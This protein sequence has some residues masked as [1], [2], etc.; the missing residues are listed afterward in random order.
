METF[1]STTETFP[2]TMETFPS[3]TETFQS[4]IATIQSGNATAQP[5][6]QHTLGVALDYPASDFAKR[7]SQLKA[8]GAAE[9]VI[10]LT[11]LPSREAWQSLLETAEASGLSW[12]LW[13]TNLPRTEGWT[14]APE[15]YRLAGSADGVYTLTV[16]DATRLLLAVSPREAPYLRLSTVL[17]LSNGRALT[18]IGDTAESVLLLYPLR[19]NALPDLWDDW[20]A[21]RDALLSLLRHRAPTRGFRGWLLQSDWDILS[22][23]T[24]PTSPLAQAEWQAYLR[25]RY[26]DLTEL[27]RAWDTS[28]KLERHEQAARLMPLWREGRGLP[29]LIA[30]D[31][32]VKPQELDANRSRFWDD[33]RAFLLERWRVLAAGLREMLTRYTPNADFTILQTAPDPAELPTPDAFATRRRRLAGICPPRDATCGARNCCWRRCAASARWNR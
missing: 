8:Q 32:S 5:A 28:T 17:E 4:T 11:A 30:P 19:P 6:K 27:E 29:H 21:Y 24:L 9:V 20:D 31:E 23:S 15:R 16:P 13:L 3:T 1:P 26:P 14:I 33:W 22:V 2:S 12:R 18:A 10:R 25:T 7:L